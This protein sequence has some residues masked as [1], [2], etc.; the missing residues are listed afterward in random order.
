[1]STSGWGNLGESSSGREIYLR[2]TCAPR[3]E[4]QIQEVCNE[5]RKWNW[6]LGLGSTVGKIPVY[7]M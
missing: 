4:K 6:D 2:G 7:D 3:L 1:L 5:K